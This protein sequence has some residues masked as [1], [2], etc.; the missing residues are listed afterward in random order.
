MCNYVHRGKK[1]KFKEINTTGYGF[2]LFSVK[3]GKLH[4][5]A[6]PVCEYTHPHNPDWTD[7]D[8]TH[9]GDGFCFF[10]TLA[11]IPDTLVRDA[12]IV[13]IIYREGLGSFLEP[14]SVYP[15]PVRIA[16]CK[17]FK[18]DIAENFVDLEF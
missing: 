8:N 14:G 17:S 9:E 16:I 15:Q 18:P 1:A 2:K 10:L 11:D 3:K 6:S 7:W 5:W 12:I 4:G 13:P